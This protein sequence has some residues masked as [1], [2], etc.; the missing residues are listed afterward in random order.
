LFITHPALIH[1]EKIM[2]TYYPIGS[3][4][5]TTEQTLSSSSSSS[6]QSSTTELDLSKYE[7]YLIRDVRKDFKGKNIDQIIDLVSENS[8]GAVVVMMEQTFIDIDRNVHNSSSSSTSSAS[9]QAVLNN[10]RPIV[11]FAIR[12]P[13]LPANVNFNLDGRSI[14]LLRVARVLEGNSLKVKMFPGFAQI[15][16]DVDPS[17]NVH[18]SALSLVTP[19]MSDVTAESSKASINAIIASSKQFAHSVNNDNSDYTGTHLCDIEEQKKGDWWKIALHTVFTTINNELNKRKIK[20]I[21]FFPLDYSRRLFVSVADNIEKMQSLTPIIRIQ[22]VNIFGIAKKYAKDSP[23]YREV[24]KMEKPGIARDSGSNPIKFVLALDIDNPHS[25]E[26]LIPID[27]DGKILLLFC[28]EPSYSRKLPEKAIIEKDAET[29]SSAISTIDTISSAQDLQAIEQI[30]TV[31][32]VMMHNFEPCERLKD[33]FTK[34][35]TDKNMDYKSIVIKKLREVFIYLIA[36]IHLDSTPSRERDAST[37]KHLR[38]YLIDNDAP[39]LHWALLDTFNRISNFKVHGNW[40]TIFNRVWQEGLD[41]PACEKLMLQYMVNDLDTL[42]APLD[43][44]QDKMETANGASHALDEQLSGMIVQYN[45]KQQPATVTTTSTATSNKNQ[46]TIQQT[47]DSATAAVMY[48]KNQHTTVQEIPDGKMAQFI[49]LLGKAGYTL[50]PFL[51]NVGKTSAFS[52]LLP[53]TKKIITD[54]SLRSQQTTASDGKLKPGDNIT[55]F[56]PSHSAST[57]M[58]ND[59]KITSTCESKQQ[60]EGKWVKWDQGHMPVTSAYSPETSNVTNTVS[61]EKPNDS[62]SKATT[63]TSEPNQQPEKNSPFYLMVIGGRS[64]NISAALN[65]DNGA[66]SMTH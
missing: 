16:T 61:P 32:Q 9:D 12:L 25:G 38:N 11:W 51:D 13:N 45:N 60:S 35:F 5:T 55:L 24:K 23:D 6:K 42:D 48:D 21:E 20:E 28:H 26:R 43:N 10:P 18:S 57:K 53:E 15:Q 40:V 34:L 33:A 59:S 3:L 63:N 49:G 47:H 39:V 44:N 19:S 64:P 52:A 62:K 46:H 14:Y 4:H 54:M 58:S 22:H 31:S 1:P 37:I 66:P 29:V 36:L 8:F 27:I 30:K 50:D 17:D 2:S 7:P 65:D 41:K 56:S